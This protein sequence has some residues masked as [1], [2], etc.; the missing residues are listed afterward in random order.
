[1]SCSFE[2][3][4]EQLG[5]SV[6][7]L[8]HHAQIVQKLYSLCMLDYK[9]LRR[10]EAHGLQDHIRK[11][12]RINI[13]EKR[14]RQPK[15]KR[16]ESMN[17]SEV[18]WVSSFT[19]V[20]IGNSIPKNFQ[21]GEI[22][23]AIGK[24]VE[25]DSQQKGMDM[26]IEGH[27][28]FGIKRSFPDDISNQ[29]QH[30]I[31]SS[32][33]NYSENSEE[34]ME[35]LSPI[36]IINGINNMGVRKTR[37]KHEAVFSTLTPEEKDRILYDKLKIGIKKCER[38]WGI[39]HGL[40]NNY[41]KSMQ[42]F[43]NIEEKKIWME[44]QN[45]KQEE[46]MKIIDTSI[47]IQNIENTMIKWGSDGIS[48][49]DLSNLSFDRGI[50][51]AAARYNISLFEL[52]FLLQ[53]LCLGQWNDME[54]NF[55]YCLPLRNTNRKVHDMSR[56]EIVKLSQDEGIQYASKK[57]G[58]DRETIHKYRKF[59]DKYGAQALENSYSVSGKVNKEWKSTPEYF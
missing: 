53:H 16:E 52:E 35:T 27:N 23:N 2:F 10:Q 22:D 50:A 28:P 37:K 59:Y 25:C 41:I 24:C 8:T 17:F 47:A 11:T 44:T 42:I 18:P 3:R 12:E 57:S 14:L 30:I 5:K 46:R 9:T 20:E 1:M 38:K 40:L 26:N 48:W 31:Q 54:K 34:S 32:S 15:K 13:T 29:N 49:R 55:W 56:L 33:S 6:Q 4:I 36:P 51:V 39:S 7:D 45:I 43:K 58:M 19:S 21:M